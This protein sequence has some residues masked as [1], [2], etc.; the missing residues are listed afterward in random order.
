MYLAIAGDAGIW[1]D[2]RPWTGLEITG[3]L[4]VERARDALVTGAGRGVGGE[5]ERGL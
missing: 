3:G 1:S 4:E 2:A 5:A